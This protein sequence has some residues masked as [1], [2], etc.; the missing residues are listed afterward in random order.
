MQLKV[1]SD[2][3]EAHKRICPL[4]VIFQLTQVSINSKSSTLFIS[5]A[6]FSFIEKKGGN[7]AFVTKK[8]Y[9]FP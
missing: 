9:V 5:K 6:L 3:G 4:K 7:F 2:F 8:K 1:D